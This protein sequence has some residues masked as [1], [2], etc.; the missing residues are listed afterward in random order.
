MPQADKSIK[1]HR[2]T[3]TETINF[4]RLKMREQ[5]EWAAF[6]VS[7]TTT[8]HSTRNTR[9]WF[10]VMVTPK[11]GWNWKKKF[12]FFPPRRIPSYLRDIALGVT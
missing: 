12:P 1:R 6:S 2:Q 3:T 8:T 9:P 10:V 7:K 11:G 5:L 4:P